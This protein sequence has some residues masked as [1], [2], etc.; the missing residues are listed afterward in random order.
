[1]PVVPGTVRADL[2]CHTHHSHDGIM[3][4]P[5]II[6]ACQKARINCLAVTD[7]NSIAGAIEV[8]REAPFPVIVGEEIKTSEGEIIGLFLEEAIPKGLSP[9]ETVKRIRSQGGLVLVPHPFDHLR[10]ST[11]R[12]EALE[13]VAQ[14]VDIIEVFNARIMFPRHVAQARAFALRHNLRSS[15]GSDAHT[16]SEIGHAYVEMAG[17]RDR[18]EFLKNLAQGT[19]RGRF[20]SPLVHAQTT[21]NR[22][23]KKRAR[24]RIP[25]A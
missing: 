14:L 5:D 13:R 21:W 11:I 20:T 8:A 18:D 12:R 4:P 22:W 7:H 17:F 25:G 1:M 10:R 19:V 15:A 24:G 3:R 23:K 16:R 2:H 6:A 9:E